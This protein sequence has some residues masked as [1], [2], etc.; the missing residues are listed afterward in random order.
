MSFTTITKHIYQFSTNLHK[1]ALT[2]AVARASKETT[3][4]WRLKFQH[5]KDAE[6][7]RNLLELEQATLV[8]NALA[9]ERACDSAI[10]ELDAFNNLGNAPRS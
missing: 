5:D 1:H 8:D 3:A 2:A 10:E 4:A 9:C 7:I 6:R